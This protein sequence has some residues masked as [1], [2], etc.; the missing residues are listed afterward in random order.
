MNDMNQEPIKIFVQYKLV[1]KRHIFT[2]RDPRG[3]GLCVVDHDAARAYDQVSLELERLLR[4]NHQ[5][6]ATVKP[7]RTRLQFLTWLDGYLSM[8]RKDSYG[9]PAQPMSREGVPTMRLS[10]LH[11]TPGGLACPVS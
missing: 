11:E 1:G 6:H 3:L 5:I 7:V 4:L 9:S 10:L 2:S 8:T